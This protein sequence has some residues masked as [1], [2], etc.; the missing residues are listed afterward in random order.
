M[1]LSVTCNLQKVN[2]H[3]VLDIA[4]RQHEQHIFMC[5][6][7]HPTLF[8]FESR[9]K[10]GIHLFKEQKISGSSCNGERAVADSRNGFARSAQRRCML[11]L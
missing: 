8:D 10:R 6:L 3:G 11:K 4:D 7:V 9:Q 1:K 2:I 5:S